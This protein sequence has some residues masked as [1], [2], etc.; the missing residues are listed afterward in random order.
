LRLVI[1]SESVW[2]VSGCCGLSER[3]MRRAVCQVSGHKNL[4]THTFF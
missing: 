4:R 3:S 1:C 2:N